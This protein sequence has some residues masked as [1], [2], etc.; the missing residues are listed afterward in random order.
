MKWLICLLIGVVVFGLLPL[1]TAIAD[2]P[3]VEWEKTFGGSDWDFGYSIQQT[4]DGGY[5]IAGKTRSFG[6]GDYDVY[7]VKTDSEGNF[8]WHKTFGG[9]EEDEGSSVQQTTDGGFIIA[10][11]TGYIGNQDLYLVKTDMNGNKLWQKIFSKSD[12]E[13]GY[14]VQQ[15]IDG[16]FIISGGTYFWDG[17]GYEIYLIKT[18]SAGNLQWEKT[19][20]GSG[21]DW[22]YSVRQTSDGGYIIAGDTDS[23]G[24]GGSDAYLVKTNSEGN[25]LW[26]KTFGGSGHDWVSSVE[27]TSDGG[28]IICGDTGSFGAEGWDI[29]LVKT[30][31]TGNLIWQKNFGGSLHDGGSSAQQT[32]DGGF[33][34]AGRAN[35]GP[36]GQYSDAYL[37]KTDFQGNLLWEKTLGGSNVDQASSVQQIS[38][39]GYIIAG[40]TRSFG[41]GNY[42]LYLIK[43]GLNKIGLTATNLLDGKRIEL[44]WDEGAG[45][46][47]LVRTDK[48]GSN[49]IGWSIPSA[50]SFTDNSVKPGKTYKYILKSSQTGEVISNEAEV[51]VEVIIVLVR[52]ISVGYKKIHPNC[53]KPEGNP[54]FVD[55]AQWF[56]DNGVTCWV[57]PQ[58]QGEGEGLSGWKTV[59]DNAYELDK[60]I[61]EQLAGPYANHRPSKINILG[62]SM[63]GLTARRYVVKYNKQNF[64]DKIFTTQTPHTGSSLAD[65][66]VWLEDRPFLNLVN[67]FYPIKNPATENLTWQWLEGFNENNVNLG[68]DT[69]LYTFW[70]SN[71]TDFTD[72]PKL[73]IGAG[74]ISLDL[75]Y[76]NALYP[77]AIPFVAESDGAV[78][79]L[80]ATGKIRTLESGFTA[81]PRVQI[82]ETFNSNLDHHSVKRH[83][84]TLEKIMDLMG[85]PYNKAVGQSVYSVPL[86]AESGEPNI[87]PLYFID[88]FA[89][90]FNS[91]NPVS[92]TVIIGN[93]SKAYFRLVCSDP[94]CVFT[95]TDPCDLNYDP[96]YALS[97]PNVIYEEE[98]G[99]FFY[100]INSPIPGVWAIKLVTQVSPPN[101][102]DYG[103]SVFEDERIE[104]SGYTNPSWANIGD[105]ILVV[106]TIA[107]NDNPLT[108]VNIVADIILSDVNAW[109]FPLYDDGFHNDA[110][111]N[112]GVYA[113]IFTA[114]LQGGTYQGQ[115]TATGVSSLGVDFE[116]RSSL[117]FTISPLEIDF[118]GDINDTGIDLNA[119]NLYDIIE[120]TMPIDVNEPNE[121]LL[122]ATLSDSNDNLIKLLSTGSVSLPTGPN[123]FTLEV[124]AEDIVKHNVDGPYTLFDIAISNAGTGLIIASNADYNT[125]P[126]LVSDFEQI[127]SDGDGLSDN[128]ELSIG[129]DPNLPDSDYDG[130]TDYS[131]VGFD[132][133]ASSYNPTTDLNPLSSDTDS[134]GMSDGWELYWGFDPLN[135]DGA[136]DNDDDTDELT[137]IQ[138]YRNNTEPNNPDTDE[139][140]MPDGWEV[141]YWLNPVFFNSDLDDD[142]D[143]LTN[144]LEYQ[145]NIDPND[146]DSDDDG[147]IDGNEVYVYGTDPNDNDTDDDS[148]LDGPDN[149]KLIYNL[150]QY[151]MDNDGKGDEC[152]CL[153]DMNND[154]IV[155][156]EDLALFVGHWLDTGC[157]SPD[158]CSATDFNKSSRVDLADFAIFAQKWLE[159]I[160]P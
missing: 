37:I 72:D 117:S 114:T 26:Q 152:D 160:I 27:H 73:K 147:I 43:V 32:Y 6:A 98:D 95:L 77:L 16:G 20:G 150:E 15:T 129:T 75:R 90:D 126:Y 8:Q 21:H 4:T 1:E 104:L 151:D 48:D 64:V 89:G 56:E 137:N 108:D 155:N 67:V 61:E 5:I 60:F 135:D 142:H 70:S 10:G 31:P 92:R 154:D 9:I 36:Y 143:Y 83:H 78:P 18:D 127:D 102:V 80:S 82:T 17:R 93:S 149:C 62:H 106:A 39:G 76:W 45:G 144:L 58:G 86:Q 12:Y 50:D 55:V 68:D 105:E 131:E 41:A 157:E 107:E 145:Y 34:I 19:L 109:S 84:T 33:I 11:T 97:D 140:N 2:G 59:E 88:G 71:F 65:L 159:D 134:D 74:I 116:R 79:V 66:R 136:K 35:S 42:D 40:T 146:P 52:G 69:Q 110:N 25:L 38:D 128:L 51:K 124:S 112:D 24:S 47:Y 96:N 122:T 22:G 133:D 81:K 87:I 30:D 111:S 53:W 101:S 130:V 49:E 153:P 57:P 119:N 158:F 141:S 85:L 156:S 120:F 115:L 13:L 94:N 3:F 118:A 113:N 99:I 125:A 29:Y 103:L 148:I 91:L 123:N 7:L 54:Y 46:V 100:D 63:G 44:Q 139:D 138:E 23:F 28:Y 132:G 14:S 121:Y